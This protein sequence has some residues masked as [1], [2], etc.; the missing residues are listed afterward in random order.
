VGNEVIGLK[1]GR[2][3]H[4]P[5]DKALQIQPHFNKKVYELINSL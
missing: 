3:F 4:M 1:N 2:I 5:L